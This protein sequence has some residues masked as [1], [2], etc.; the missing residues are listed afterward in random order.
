MR[1]GRIEG[2]FEMS[3]THTVTRAGTP[4][5]PVYLLSID[6][7]E[8]LGCGRCFKVCG[9]NVLALTPLD[10]EGEAAEDE[11]DIERYVMTVADAG[12]ASVAA[13][14]HASA[15]R[16][17]EARRRAGVGSRVSVSQ[18]RQIRRRPCR[19]PAKTRHFRGI[20]IGAQLAVWTFDSTGGDHPELDRKCGFAIRRLIVEAR[21]RE[22]LG[23]RIAVHGGGLRRRSL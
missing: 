5:E 1:L 16:L 4:W 22:I 7:A 12:I 9:R 10:E 21:D 2:E 11:E 14:V 17:S 23:V 6:A 18:S 20:S 8:C 3:G 13:P 15:P 19:I